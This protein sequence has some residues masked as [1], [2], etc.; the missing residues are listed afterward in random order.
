MKTED[1]KQ[2][3]IAIRLTD[4]QYQMIKKASDYEG[5]SIGALARSYIFKTLRE[6]EKKYERRE[7]SDV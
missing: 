1:I 5:I 2:N 4:K 7:V 3:T 6:W